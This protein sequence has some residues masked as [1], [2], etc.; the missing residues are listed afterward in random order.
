M[1]ILSRRANLNGEGIFLFS[2]ALRVLLFFAERK[3][4]SA[5]VNCP[6]LAVSESI[7]KSKVRVAIRSERIRVQFP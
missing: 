5:F 4:I 3:T 7:R 6:S 2:L 1:N